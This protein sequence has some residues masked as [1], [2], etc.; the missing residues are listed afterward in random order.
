MRDARPLLSRRQLFLLAGAAARLEG[1]ES[2]FWNSKPAA[3]WSAG[4]IYRLANH[5]P[6]V[7][8]VQAWFGPKGVVTWE[9]AQPMREYRGQ[10]AV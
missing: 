10:L 3:Q 7:N 9:S 8:P 5:S 2:G 4:D 1:S 6:W